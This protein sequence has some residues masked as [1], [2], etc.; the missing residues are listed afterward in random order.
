MIYAYIRD[1]IAHINNVWRVVNF[2]VTKNPILIMLG[3]NTNLF[4]N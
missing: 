1:D 2:I 4:K 3:L